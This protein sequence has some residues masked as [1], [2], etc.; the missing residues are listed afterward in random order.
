MVR[1]NIFNKCFDKKKQKR[2]YQKSQNFWVRNE[3][4]KEKTWTWYVP[5]WSLYVILKRHETH[6]LGRN[7]RKAQ[8]IFYFIVPTHIMWDTSTSTTASTLCHYHYCCVLYKYTV[9]CVGECV[10]MLYICMNA[11]NRHHL[12]PIIQKVFVIGI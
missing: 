10:I 7:P 12:M 11:I 1:K 4:C 8:T 3:R 2:E 5:T 9:V 6:L